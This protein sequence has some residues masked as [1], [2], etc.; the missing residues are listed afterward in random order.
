[1]SDGMVEQL[2]HKAANEE[3]ARRAFAVMS[4]NRRQRRAARV[5]NGTAKI[6]GLNKPFVKDIAKVKGVDK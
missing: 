5:V 3:N 6:P 4:L 2:N 1:M